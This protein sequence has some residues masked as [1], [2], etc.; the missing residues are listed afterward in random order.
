MEYY[1][2]ATKKL[3]PPPPLESAREDSMALR[4]LDPVSV[5]YGQIQ[6]AWDIQDR[7]RLSWWDALI[8]AAGLSIGCR[9]LL[10][11]DLQDGSTMDGLTVADPFLQGPEPLLAD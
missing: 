9:D 1:V 2:T 10:S 8:V 6:R 4:A 7:F 3:T 5:D 11:A